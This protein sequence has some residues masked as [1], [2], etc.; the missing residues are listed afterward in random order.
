MCKVILIER[1]FE[2]FWET[3]SPRTQRH[4]KRLWHTMCKISSVLQNWLDQDKII[5]DFIKSYLPKYHHWYHKEEQDSQM[6]MP[7]MWLFLGFS[8]FFLWSPLRN[9]EKKSCPNKLKFWQASRNHLRSLSWK[10]QYSILKKVETS[11]I[12]ASISE[13]PVPLC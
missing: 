11:H 7:T 6:W 4:K 1:V 13:N 12:L 3:N 10:V 9:Y 2:V 8:A 5:S